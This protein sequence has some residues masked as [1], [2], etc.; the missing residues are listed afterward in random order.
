M[1]MYV[2][3]ESVVSRLIAGET[4]IIP[5]RKGVGDLASI[6]SLNAVATVIWQSVSGPRSVEEIAH[7]LEAEFAGERDRIERDLD[8]F[9]KEM[10]SAGLI[11]EVEVA[12]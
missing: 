8:T 12:A 6:Y 2:R 11:N 4:L 3:S 10:N 7:A 9:L 5:V 1:Q